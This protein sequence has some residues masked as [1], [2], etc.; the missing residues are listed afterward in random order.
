MTL[1]F[2]MGITTPGKMVSNKRQGPEFQI[3]PKWV[4]ILQVR[5]KEPKPI[6]PNLNF[7]LIHC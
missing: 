6:S 3:I 7:E 2:I 4:I 5:G 1:I